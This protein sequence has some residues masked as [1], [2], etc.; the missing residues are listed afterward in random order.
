MKPFALTLP[1]KTTINRF[2][3]AR[4]LEAQTKLKI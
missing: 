2:D 4:E 1:A 3:E